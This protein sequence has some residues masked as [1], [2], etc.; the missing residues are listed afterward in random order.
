MTPTK[1]QVVIFTNVEKT[2]TLPNQGSTGGGLLMPFYT[3]WNWKGQD[4]EAVASSSKQCKI[5]QTLGW[6]CEEFWTTM[7]SFGTSKLSFDSHCRLAKWKDWKADN[8]WFH[9]IID[10]I[11]L[12]WI[13]RIVVS[14]LDVEFWV[15]IKYLELLVV[16]WFCTC[17]VKC[18]LT[19]LMPLTWCGFLQPLHLQAVQALALM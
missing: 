14:D 8:L 1:F 9:F 3:N 15:E 2:H 6:K 4:I 10:F 11:Q 19:T 7:Q 12:R 5:H 13:L 16:F 18:G 17:I